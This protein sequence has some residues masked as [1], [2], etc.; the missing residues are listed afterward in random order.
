MSHGGR[1]AGLSQ[2]S[3]RPACLLRDMIWLAASAVAAAVAAAVAQELNLP[4]VD[5]ML[6]HAPGGGSPAR[7]RA[8]YTTRLLP[9]PRPTPAVGAAAHPGVSACALI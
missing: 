3:S 7:H 5:L 6:I 8:N 1:R 4:R 9:M 2:S